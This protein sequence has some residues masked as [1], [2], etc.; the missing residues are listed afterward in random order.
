ME[1]TK[2]SVLRP[3]LDRLEEAEQQAFLEA[4][5]A[6]VRKAYPRLN[7]GKTVL[8]FKRLFFIAVK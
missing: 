5:G 7:D 2:G 8:P 6:R 3:F 1:W 4:Y